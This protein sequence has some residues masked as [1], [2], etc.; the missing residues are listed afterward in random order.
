MH[1]QKFY[2]K[3]G[4]ASFFSKA[5]LENIE[6]TNAQ[7]MSVLNTTNGEIQF[8]VLIKAFRFK[9][10]LMEEHFNE[11]YMESKK[12]PKAIFKGSIKDHEKIILT[13]NGSYPVSVSG[14][15]TIHGVTEKVSTEGMVSVKNGICSASAKFTIKPKDY[16]I[17]IPKI[18][19]K[20]IAEKIDITI[21]CSYDQTLK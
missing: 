5:P 14:H 12:Y 18:V 2:T 16:N 15:M 9:K 4:N 21:A 20:N 10:A 17:S 6:A 13:S 19:R 11:N 3:N 1:A 8:S 7:V